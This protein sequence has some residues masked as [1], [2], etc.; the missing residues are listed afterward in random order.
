MTWLLYGREKWNKVERMMNSVFKCLMSAVC[1]VALPAFG[2]EEKTGFPTDRAVTVFSAG[3]GNPYAS[4]RIP[5]LLSIGKGQLLA[6]AEGRYKNTDQGENDIIM[7]VSKNGGKTW[8]RP[9]A[10]AKAH[11]ATFN[12]PCPVYDAKTRTVTVV[13]QRYPAGVKERQP[14]IPDGW[15]D[16]KCIRNF[17]IQS[18][19][20]GSSWTK[21]QEITKTTKRPSGVD[22]MA[23]GPNAGTQL[24]SGA[25]KGRRVIPMNEGPFGKWVISCIYSDD[26]GKSWKLSQPTANMKGMVNETSIAETDNGGVVMVARHW[27]AGKCRCIAWSW[28]G[29]ESWG[30]VWDAPELFC[31]SNHNSLMTYSLSDQPAYGGKSRILFSGEAVNGNLGIFGASLITALRGLQNLAAY[32]GQWD[33]NFTGHTGWGGDTFLTSVSPSIFPT[34]M[35]LM[36]EVLDGSLQGDVHPTPLGDRYNV[37]RDGVIVSYDPARLKDPV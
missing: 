7:S 36:Q 32:A 3:E 13:F 4:I 31:D 21:P 26:G 10:I 28:D 17:M 5:A 30:P 20:G 27:G 16:E 15:D 11:G 1:A 22:I 34:C 19:N 25:H 14:N 29:V 23:S 35:A 18:R 6:F 33:R 37:V 12:N 2:Q 24:K 9:R 8:S